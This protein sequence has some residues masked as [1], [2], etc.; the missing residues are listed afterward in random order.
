MPIIIPNKVLLVYQLNSDNTATL[1]Y[2]TETLANSGFSA[3]GDKFAIG[4]PVSLSTSGQVN[5]NPIIVSNK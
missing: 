3:V 5:T 2:S 4:A 1:K